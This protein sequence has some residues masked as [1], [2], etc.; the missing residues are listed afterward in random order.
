MSISLIKK[1]RVCEPRKGIKKARASVPSETVAPQSRYNYHPI[2]MGKGRQKKRHRQ[3]ISEKYYRKMIN[4]TFPHYI[5]NNPDRRDVSIPIAQHD[6]S[7][8]LSM[9]HPDI[10]AC[11][12]TILLSS[13]KRSPWKRQLT[14]TD[15]KLAEN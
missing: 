10:S 5:Y 6:S 13:T 1:N 7:R 14:K 2:S 12:I 15:Y 4:L 9:I 3:A 11:S 8:Y